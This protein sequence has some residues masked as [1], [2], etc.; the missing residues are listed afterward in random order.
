MTG[1]IQPGE[2]LTADYWFRNLRQPVRLDKA[3]ATA[4]AQGPSLFIESSPHPVL[5]TPIQETLEASPTTAATTGT[6]RRDQDGPATFTASLAQAH[7]FGLRVTWP[8]AHPGR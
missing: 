5:T 1:Q 3:I 2:D 7:S 6:L 4:L 8:T